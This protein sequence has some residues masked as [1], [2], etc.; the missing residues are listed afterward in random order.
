MISTLRGVVI[1]RS[2]ALGQSRE[3]TDV[4][5][6]VV[7]IDSGKGHK[8]RR[9]HAFIRQAIREFAASNP[10]R[11]TPQAVAE[12]IFDRLLGLKELPPMAQ[13]QP[14]LESMVRDVIRQMLREGW[15]NPAVW[16][17]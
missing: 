14:L 7:S 6:N 1:R 16:K 17:D 4:S 12:S 11:I 8:Q 10:P 13:V 5:R 3:G 15:E 2:G 9:L